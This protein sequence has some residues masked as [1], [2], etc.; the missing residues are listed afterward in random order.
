MYFF[1]LLEA[2]GIYV[3]QGSEFRDL[4]GTCMLRIMFFLAR[5]R[6]TRLCERFANFIILYFT[7]ILDGMHKARLTDR[8]RAVY[9]VDINDCLRC[10]G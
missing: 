2:T 8:N 4:Y 5:R 10:K 1:D 9:F 7:T 3:V 6:F